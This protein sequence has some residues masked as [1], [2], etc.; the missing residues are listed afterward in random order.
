[1]YARKVYE[2]TAQVGA[3]KTL[4]IYTFTFNIIIIIN[5]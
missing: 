3:V 4:Y 1:M 2:C 5:G